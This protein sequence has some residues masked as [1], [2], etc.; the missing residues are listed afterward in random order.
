MNDVDDEEEEEEEEEDDG[1]AE[2]DD[3]YVFC[4]I[5]GIMRRSEQSL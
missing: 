4:V 3:D 2:D 5:H 1:D